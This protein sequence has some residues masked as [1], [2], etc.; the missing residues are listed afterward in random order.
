MKLIFTKRSGAVVMFPD[1][2]GLSIKYHLSLKM[3]GCCVGRTLATR[4]TEMALPTRTR[5][6]NYG[7]RFYLINDPYVI[8]EPA[9]HSCSRRHLYIYIYI[10]IYKVVSMI[11][12]LD[13]SCELL[14]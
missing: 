1:S 10:Y 6:L 3:K 5:V 8:P 4:A 11:K 14:A 13:I 9:A 12:G 7:P 2:E